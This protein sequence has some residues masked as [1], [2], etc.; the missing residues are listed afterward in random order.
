M[1]RQRLASRRP[2]A[3]NYLLLIRLALEGLDGEAFDAQLE[4]F[5]NRAEIWRRLLADYRPAAAAAAQAEAEN[6][7]ALGT[8]GF[9][10]V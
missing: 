8:G 10:Q 7:A 1:P 9:M 2:K 4:A 6:V 3:A 5:I